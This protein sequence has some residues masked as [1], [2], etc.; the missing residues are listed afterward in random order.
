[1]VTWSVALLASIKVSMLT[2]GIILNPFNLYFLF[3]YLFVTIHTFIYLFIA[4]YLF[5]YFIDY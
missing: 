3:G 4:I 2:Q 5:I 1:M